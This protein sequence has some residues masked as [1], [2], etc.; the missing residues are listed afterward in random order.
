MGRACISFI[1]SWLEIVSL[2]LWQRLNIKMLFRCL[3]LKNV[4][5]INGITFYAF[6]QRRHHDAKSFRLN[7]WFDDKRRFISTHHLFQWDLP[8]SFPPI[9]P[10]PLTLL[11]LLFHIS[12]AAPDAGPSPHC[13]CVDNTSM[14]LNSLLPRLFFPSIL[15]SNL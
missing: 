4:F 10:S 14:F 9:P 8:P 2:Q 7:D 15:L 5:G 12:F 11:L 6:E 3:W 1:C 13:L